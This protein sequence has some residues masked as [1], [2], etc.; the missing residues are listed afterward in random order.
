MSRAAR[1]TLRNEPDVLP[2]SLHATLD[3]PNVQPVDAT[4]SPARHSGHAGW[5]QG[6]YR[7]CSRDGLLASDAVRFRLRPRMP[8][9]RAPA[10]F[11]DRAGA[12]RLLLQRRA[13]HDLV[14]EAWGRDADGPGPRPPKWCAWDLRL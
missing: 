6:I 9:H 8:L 3:E 14:R 7:T 10:R 5:T 4:S 11:E 2:L 13:E 12:G 1:I